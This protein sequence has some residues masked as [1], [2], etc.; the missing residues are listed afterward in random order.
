MVSL[1]TKFLPEEMLNAIKRTPPIYAIGRRIRFAL[2]T[3][4]G[5]RAVKGISGR[6]H[7]NDFMLNS[8]TPS[9]VESYQRGA[10]QFVDILERSISEAGR[11]WASIG[12]CL[13][14]GCGYGRIVRELR[15]HLP[16]SQ[17]Y[18]SDVIDEGAVF[19]AREFGVHKA[20]VFE[21]AGD[22]LDDKFDLIYLLSVYTHLRRD[23]VESNL[24]RVAAALKP[25]GVVIF[26]VHG[27]GSAQTSE[28]Y[29]QYWLDKEKL[30]AALASDGYYYERY[31]YY[32][33]E[34]GL[35]WFTRDAV[36]A[37]VEET[38]PQLQFIAHHPTELDGH[39]DI[40]VYRA[41]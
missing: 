5:A 32:S 31:P 17:I 20:P 30:L 35:T 25:G 40:F 37:M 1:P 8:T 13:E 4:L 16:A 22:S 34:Y 14:V 12:A 18:V 39:Q 28:R 24:R 41:V 11:D 21:E 29:R 33:T 2:G 9:D 23:F 36:T 26:T 19:A 15:T 10:K 27:E 7:Y 3:V 6:V 38:V